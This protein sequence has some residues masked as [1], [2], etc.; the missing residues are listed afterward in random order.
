MSTAREQRLID[1]LRLVLRKR[2]RLFD[3]T[4]KVGAKNIGENNFWIGYSMF[5][6]KQIERLNYFDL[7]IEGDICYLLNIELEEK[8]H[9]M[10]LGK[11][12]YSSIEEF[13]RRERCSRVRMTPSG[14]AI[15]GESRRD[16]IHR[17]G[18]LDVSPNGE[19]EKI[20]RL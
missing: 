17:L 20:V 2:F 11:Q 10:G 7:N 14:R 3:E 12:L 16:Y 19:V 18:Y 13:A 9:G 8:L 5:G 1:S 6:F 15:T 4:H